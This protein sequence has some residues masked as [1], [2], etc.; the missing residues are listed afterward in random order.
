MGRF[1]QTVDKNNEKINH[2]CSRYYYEVSLN[3]NCNLIIGV[4]QEDEREVGVKEMRP[5]LDIGLII[6]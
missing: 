1:I 5:Y 6:M 4:H 3:Q 2:F